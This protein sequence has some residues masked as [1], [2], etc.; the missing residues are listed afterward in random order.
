MPFTAISSR[1][2]S[3]RRQIAAARE[4]TMHPIVAVVA[5]EAVELEAFPSV[6]ALFA[7]LGVV[8]LTACFRCPGGRT[9]RSGLP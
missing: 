2:G 9:F 5:V 7:A 3:M 1:V 8:C 6:A 4:Q